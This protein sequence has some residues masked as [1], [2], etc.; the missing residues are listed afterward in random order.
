[1]SINYANWYIFLSFFTWFV[2]NFNKNIFSLHYLQQYQ[3]L[4]DILD[5]FFYTHQ[6]HKHLTQNQY[7][8]N[9][10][11]LVQLDQD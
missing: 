3:I 9:D 10:N 6:H 5:H 8:Q 2:Y 11:F 4:K 1:M 7:A